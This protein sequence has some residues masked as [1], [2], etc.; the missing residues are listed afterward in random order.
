MPT[1]KVD[2][3]FRYPPDIWRA[4]LNACA[5][6]G[7]NY[8]V[9]L[10][11]LATWYTVEKRLPESGHSSTGNTYYAPAPIPEQMPVRTSD[12]FINELLDN[13]LFQ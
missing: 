10:L 7:Q 2:N 6:T 3:R 5:E 11:Q 13:E 9:V 1:T 4:F 12:A 8:K